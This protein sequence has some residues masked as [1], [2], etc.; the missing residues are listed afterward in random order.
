MQLAKYL[1]LHWGQHLKNITQNNSILTFCR[2]C[3]M[4]SEISSFTCFFSLIIY[5]EN[6]QVC[7]AYVLVGL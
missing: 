6:G 1:H 2:K 4:E 7:V 3:Y 5:D